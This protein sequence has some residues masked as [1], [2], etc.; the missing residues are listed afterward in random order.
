MPAPTPRPRRTQAERREATTGKLVDA[1]IACLAERGYA[2]TSVAAI[3]GRAGVSQGALFRHFATRADVIVAAADEI[4]R[5]HLAQFTAAAPSLRADAL[6]RIVVL[7]RALTRTDTHAAWR[8]IMVAARTDPDLRDAAAE[9]L[10]SFE[11]RLID[12]AAQFLGLDPR[13]AERVAVVLLSVMHMF[14][15]EAVTVTV[16]ANERLERERVR[17]ATQMLA[18]ELAVLVH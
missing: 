2:N 6:E 14:D 3:C 7:V 13:T 5:R 18:R 11:R 15:S 16:Y 1:T 12:T 9:G 10:Q 8:E 4:T 17:W